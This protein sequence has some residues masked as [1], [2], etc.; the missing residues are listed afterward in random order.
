VDEAILDRETVAFVKRQCAGAKYVMGV[1]T[2]SLML[3]A[4][5]VIAGKRSGGHWLARDLLTQF[6]ATVSD[7]RMT[8]DGKVYTSGG[9]TAGIDMAL[10]VAQDIVGLPAAEQI[11]LQIEYDPEPPFRAGTPF[12][13]PPEIVT[14]LRE[15]N[16]ERRKSREAAVT[17]AARRLTSGG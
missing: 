1:C 5:G 16:K 15:A 13:A 8:I 2:G 4:A 10:R 3:G 9:V 6:G 17:E 14:R 7:A 11:E 12:I